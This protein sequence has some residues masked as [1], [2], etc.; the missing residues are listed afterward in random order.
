MTLVRRASDGLRTRDVTGA[1]DPWAIPTNG[2][3]SKFSSAGVPVDQDSILS[4]PAV[5]RSVDIIA[6][7]IAGLPFDAVTTRGRLRIPVE[8]APM[9][10][11]DPFGGANLLSGVGLTRFEGLAQVLTSL[12]FRGNAYINI[13]GLGRDGRPSVLQVLNPDAVDC[14]YDKAGRRDYTVNREPFPTAKML[15]IRGLTLPGQPVGLSVLSYAKR[16]MGL[17]IAAEEF[18]SMFFGN[19][20]HLSGFISV[21]GDMNPDRAREMKEFYESKHGGMRH[22]H[23][24]SVLTGGAKF[25][26][27]SITPEE[28]QF[29][30]TRQF[31]NS[32]IAMLFGLPPHL[33][34]MTDKTTSWGRGIEEQ[35]LGFLKYT[36]MRWIKPLEDAFSIL[37][38]APQKARFNLDAFARSDLTGRMQAY[39]YARNA[40]VMTPNE[41][42]ALENLGPVD[43]GDDL[44]ASLN[45]AHNAQP[46]DE[47]RDPDGH[48]I[49]LT[50]PQ[51]KP[52]P[53]EQGNGPTEGP[54]K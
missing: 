39:Q 19:G 7:S 47:P 13:A 44:F 8:P 45:S 6:T 17:A 41:I 38:P 22:A 54:Q 25:V 40:S 12:L 33:L 23:E 42:R 51:Q 10:I 9:I 43:G 18:G 5:T 34:G 31:Q 32:D 29:L 27:L 20:V 16:T 53:T 46:G 37:L 35:D 1:G 48:P 24:I 52:A 21:E 15:H 26:P 3:L 11:E 28:A 4:L 50:Q 36:L 30:A 49:A 14:N 2:S